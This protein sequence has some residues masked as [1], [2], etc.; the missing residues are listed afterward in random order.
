MTKCLLTDKKTRIQVST[1][2]KHIIYFMQQYTK[3]ITMP[4]YVMFLFG[5]MQYK[6]NKI[7]DKYKFKRNT[8][9]SR[10]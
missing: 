6:R 9:F 4:S 3:R 8:Y 1:Q 10:Y 5:K 2:D 7:Q